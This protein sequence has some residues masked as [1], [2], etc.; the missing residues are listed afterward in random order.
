M[1]MKVVPLGDGL[2][3]EARVA[4]EDIGRLTAGMA[5][6]VK[7]RAFDYLRFGSLEAPVRRVAADATPDPGD[8]GKFA[9]AVTVVTARDHLGGRPGE[10]DV[11][12]AWS[13]TSS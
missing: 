13:S 3:V 9:Y 2:V 4:N 8:A 10:H 11:V 5:A 1:L 7:V 12:P 6:E